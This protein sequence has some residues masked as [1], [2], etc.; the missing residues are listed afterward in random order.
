MKDQRF[1]GTGVA[2][3]TPF[4]QGQVDYTA[5]GR[6][7]DHLIDGGVNYIVSLGSTG[8]AATLSQEEERAILDFT[9]QH[10]G[11]RIPVMAG[12]FGGNDTRELVDKVRSFDFTGI[13]AILSASPAYVKPSQEGIF[14]HYAAIA[15]ASPVPVMLYNVPGRTRSNM[16]WQTTIRLANLGASILGIKEA[17][18]DLV[19][20][21]HIL[22][23]APDHFL[24]LSGD[25]EL[26][27][28]LV[29][30]GGDGVISVMANALPH[31][32]SQ[33]VA[34]ALDGDLYAARTLNA[35]TYPLHQWL[36]AEGNPVGIK[37]AMEC[38]NLC[39][40]EVRLP[41]TE[42]TAEGKKNLSDILHKIQAKLQMR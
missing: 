34:T 1:I 21:S 12:N 24:V 28:P 36:Y 14:R 9:L 3:V 20:A 6:I 17:S 19:Q 27:F 41:L 33:M 2:V 7:L 37:A 4:D 13:S 15:E 22:H 35:L 30:M 31:A 23:H 25:D 18:G 10:V 32:F 39:G 5:L 26:A 16:E 38:L 42:M 11:N 40:G 8:E 29:A